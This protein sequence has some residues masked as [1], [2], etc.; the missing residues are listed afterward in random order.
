MSLNELTKYVKN[1]L[2]TGKTEEQI[3]SAIRQQGGWTEQDI[4]KAFSFNLHK[5]SYWPLFIPIIQVVISVFSFIFGLGLCGFPGDSESSTCYL[6]NYL[7]VFCFIIF[8][9]LSFYSFNF[10][11][12]SGYKTKYLIAFIVSLIIPTFLVLSGILMSS[13]QQQQATD[14][15]SSRNVIL[16]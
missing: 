10:F 5:D 9:V 7:V 2:S 4:E 16:P 8:V 3:K 6:S 11:K 15:T 14:Y 13:F 12:K 1:S